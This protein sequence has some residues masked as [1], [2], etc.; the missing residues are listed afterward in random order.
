[1]TNNFTT[2][3]AQVAALLSPGEVCDVWVIE[4]EAPEELGEVLV[5]PVSVR[6]HIPGGGE[7][8]PLQTVLSR[9]IFD[10][11]LKLLLIG[12]AGVW[13]VQDQHLSLFHFAVCP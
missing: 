9:E 4:V 5:G 1:M 7:Q 10:Q 2:S 8:E 3:L 11:G 13:G 12:V 6:N